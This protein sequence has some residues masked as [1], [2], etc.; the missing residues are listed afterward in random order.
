MNMK[1][2]FFPIWTLGNT[3]HKKT[4]LF[5][6]LIFLVHFILYNLVPGIVYCFSR[7]ETEEVTVELLSRGIKAGCYH[8]DMDAKSRSKVHRDW[9]SG[10]VQVCGFFF[11]RAASLSVFTYFCMLLTHYA[12]SYYGII[13]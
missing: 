13:V 2:F 4:V 11:S 9:L 3:N 10:E 7:K 6:S 8:A 5:L 12:C 1:T